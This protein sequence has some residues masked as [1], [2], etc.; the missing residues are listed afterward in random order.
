MLSNDS[1]IIADKL[2]RMADWLDAHPEAAGNVLAAEADYYRTPKILLYRATTLGACGVEEI[3][4]T[5]DRDGTFFT[6]QQDGIELK[7]F[8]R[9]LVAEEEVA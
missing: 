2:R 7:V 8:E 1:R 4:A 3:T 9:D 5:R 6:A